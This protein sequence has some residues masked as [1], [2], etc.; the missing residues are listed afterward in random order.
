MNLG[1]LYSANLMQRMRQDMQTIFG[2]MPELATAPD[3]DLQSA[4]VVDAV[5]SFLSQL[6]ARGMPVSNVRVSVQQAKRYTI[7]KQGCVTFQDTEGKP[8][9]VKVK[10]RN[11]SRRLLRKRATKLLG[12]NFAFLDFSPPEAKQVIDVRVNIKIPG[13]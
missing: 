8:M 9:E 12:R 5:N 10:S 2:A 13:K 1:D 6:K 7:S 11:T 4:Q 3:A